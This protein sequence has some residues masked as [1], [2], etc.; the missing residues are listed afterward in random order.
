MR[1]PSHRVAIAYL[2]MVAAI[3]VLIILKLTIWSAPGIVVSAD[4]NEVVIDSSFL[5]MYHFGLE[6][7]RIRSEQ[8]SD[9]IVDVRDDDG[10]LPDIFRLS[11]GANS[12]QLPDGTPTA[13]DLVPNTPYVLMI[14]GNN[15][16]G[17]SR[18][19]SKSVKVPAG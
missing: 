15:G 12:I 16:W 1:P 14:C 8:G 11:A 2:L 3:L 10:R 19:R 7:I 6:R 4:G 13:F 18:C 9:A 5:G 17:Q